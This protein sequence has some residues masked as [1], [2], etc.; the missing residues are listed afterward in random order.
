MYSYCVYITRHR[1]EDTPDNS[2]MLRQCQW[3]GLYLKDK[4]MYT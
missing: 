3:C 4:C 1:Y 2:H